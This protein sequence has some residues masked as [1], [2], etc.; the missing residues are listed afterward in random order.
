MQHV[1]RL[2]KEEHNKR[3]EWHRLEQVL[4]IA[5]TNFSNA[6]RAIAETQEQLPAEW[7]IHIP[8]LSP[9]MLA[10]WQREVREL[11]GATEK[12]QALME[13]RQHQGQ[14]KQSLVEL[15]NEQ[16]QLPEEAQR[17]PEQVQEE[18]ELTNAS[19]REFEMQEQKSRAEAQRLQGVRKRYRELQ[20]QWTEATRL[21]S[22]YRELAHLL[23]REG[24]QHYLLQNA[25]VGIVYHANEILD[26]ISG[27]TLRLELRL[28]SENRTKTLDMVAYN[29]SISAYEPQSIEQLSGS[30][31]FRVAISLAIGIGRYMGKASHRV[32]SIM[33]DEGFGSLD[34][35]SRDE[36]TQALQSLEDEFKCVIVVSHQNEFSDKFPNRYEATLVNGQTKI[37]LV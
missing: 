20:Q 14:S 24:L 22:R 34:A 9:E 15:E 8:H 32:E 33:I 29:S 6:Q 1:S 18:I 25:E 17:M 26:R 19:Y 11:Q 12:H 28:G 36:M 7:R 21:A 31:Q 13:A 27:A 10:R 16:R 2:T 5:K 37:A 4:G 23:G 3:E 30:Q 35:S